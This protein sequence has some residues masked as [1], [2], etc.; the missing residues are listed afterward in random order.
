MAFIQSSAN[1]LTNTI[2][3]IGSRGK[4]QE[5]M[6]F[7]V[8]HIYIYM[9]YIYIYGYYIY[10]WWETYV[11]N[12]IYIKECITNY[13]YNYMYIWKGILDRERERGFLWISFCANT[14]TPYLPIIMPHVT[15]KHGKNTDLKDVD[16]CVYITLATKN[17]GSQNPPNWSLSK[18]TN[19]LE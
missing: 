5:T 16:L 9:L 19:G 7:S 10:I 12:C 2:K 14:G 17:L 1:R 11:C 4:S 18:E 13:M 15:S 8:N 3:L 6:V